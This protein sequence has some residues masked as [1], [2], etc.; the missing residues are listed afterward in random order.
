MKR[1][2]SFFLALLV[3]APAV[4]VAQTL[5]VSAA[6]SMKESLEA[7][8]AAF[9]ARTGTHIDLALGS[10]G[11]LETQIENGAEVDVFISAAQKQVDQLAAQK[12]IDPA[13]RTVVARNAL[14]LI[15]PKGAT[16]VKGFDDLKS[17]AVRRISAGEPRVVPAGDY[18]KQV[19]DHLKLSEAV[20]DKLVYG[21]N[22]RQVL[23]YVRQ[24]EVDA[25]LVYRTDAIEAGKE[26]TIVAD[27]DPSWCKPIEY[28][29][30]VIAASK[31][32]AVA[33]AFLSYLRGDE[34]QS[35]LAKHG[36]VKGD[37]AP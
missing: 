13:S 10:S 34:G 12:L 14:A 23:A 36:F 17:P 1:L 32:K 28:P 24:G 27:A 37:P 6:I 29:G 35:E 4:C 3:F 22:V 20:K 33:Q 30:V 8:A 16:N 26:V 21:A 31:N 5:H 25:G 11:M 18:A 7:V 19:L 9:E 15:C 2:G